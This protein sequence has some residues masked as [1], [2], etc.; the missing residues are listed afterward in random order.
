MYFT[1]FSGAMMSMPVKGQAASLHTAAGEFWVDG[2]S[3]RAGS[4]TQV[5]T[6]LSES[7]F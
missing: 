2:L 1:I 6:L 7:R 4:P 5:T 3:L